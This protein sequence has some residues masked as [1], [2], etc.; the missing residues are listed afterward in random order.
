MV[1][2][3][4]H[5]YRDRTQMQR[6][7]KTW[8]HVRLKAKALRQIYLDSQWKQIDLGSNSIPGISKL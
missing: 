6:K 4:S 1:A 5:S 8:S 7:M 3:V 2:Q